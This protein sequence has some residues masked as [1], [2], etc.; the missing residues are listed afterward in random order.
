[1]NNL[2]LYGMKIKDQEYGTGL[3]SHYFGIYIEVVVQKILNMNIDETYTSI[4]TI[5]FFLHFYKNSCN[6]VEKIFYK[7]SSQEPLNLV[8]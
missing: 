2:F 3:L 4:M 5:F 6:L 8:I 7:L 1:M